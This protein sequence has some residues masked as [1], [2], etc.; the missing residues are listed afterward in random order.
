LNWNFLEPELYECALKDREA[1]VTSG[2]ALCA[3]TGVHSGRSPKDKYIVCDVQT[4]QTIW[5]GKQRQDDPRAICATVP[6]L[7]CPLRWQD[8]RSG[9]FLPEL[10]ASGRKLLILWRALGKIHADDEPAWLTI[11]IVGHLVVPS[12]LYA[13]TVFRWPLL[14]SITVWPAD[15]V[16]VDI[17]YSAACE[18]SFH[19]GNLG[20]EGSRF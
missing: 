13:E 5:V 12:A 2:G 14:M 20:D 19:R 15:G 4:E 10:S 3:E 7:H 8:L 1:Q 6:G 17:G 18:G 11:I 9:K 16:G